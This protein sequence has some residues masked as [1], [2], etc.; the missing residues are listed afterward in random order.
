MYKYFKFLLKYST[1]VGVS[2]N[3]IQYFLSLQ[4]I[5][6]WDEDDSFQVSDQE[7]AAPV[8]VAARDKPARS[9][10]AVAYK[11]DSDSDDDF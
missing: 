4:K 2:Q 11:L 6:K 10:K 9:R 5:K 1:W 7:A 3:S 8:A